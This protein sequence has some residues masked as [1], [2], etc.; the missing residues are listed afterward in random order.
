MLDVQNLSK[1]SG[2]KSLLTGLTFRLDAGNR[3]GILG[4]NGSGKTLLIEILATLVRPTSGKIEINGVDVYS[5]LGQIRPLIGYVPNTFEGYPYLT[6]LQYLDFFASAYKFEKRQIP[7]TVRNVLDLMDLSE[8]SEEKISK[9]SF[10]QRHR[11]LLAKTFF[12]NP[13]IWLLDSPISA[14][15]PRGQIELTDLITEL[16][17]MGKVIVMATNSVAE[18]EKNCE[19]VAIL[20]QS[21]FAFLGSIPDNLES[22]FV[23]ITAV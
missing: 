14:L 10:G 7:S 13:D 17:L 23:E 20:N 4:R 6:V 1:V 9:L 21:K 11:L 19:F 18:V 8:F 12:S 15:D 22:L 2:K 3:L 5:N 16:S